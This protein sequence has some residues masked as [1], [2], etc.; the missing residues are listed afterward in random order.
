MLGYQNHKRDFVDELRA[1][2]L[3]WAAKPN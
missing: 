3:A 2:A 1:T